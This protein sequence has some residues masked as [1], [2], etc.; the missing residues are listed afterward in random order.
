MSVYTFLKS[1]YKN[2]KTNTYP[3]IPELPPF[4]PDHRDSPA[5]D[6]NHRRWTMDGYVKSSVPPQRATVTSTGRTPALYEPQL[7]MRAKWNLPRFGTL[8]FTH[9]LRIDGIR[10]MYVKDEQSTSAE[11]GTSTSLESGHRNFFR[12]MVVTSYFIRLW[13]AYHKECT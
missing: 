9:A 6:N 11:H 2:L 5:T 1:K 7:I 8:S 3:S 4:L 10:G 13:C 12:I